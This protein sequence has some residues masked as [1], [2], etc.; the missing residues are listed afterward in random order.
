MCYALQTITK[1]LFFL[2]EFQQPDKRA[3]A[4]C[5]ISPSVSSVGRL[6]SFSP[7]FSEYGEI[8]DNQIP[9]EFHKYGC[10]Y[11]QRDLIKNPKKYDIATSHLLALNLEYI[12]RNWH[13]ESIEGTYPT[14]PPKKQ[15]RRGQ[16][17]DKPTKPL[18]PRFD[19]VALFVNALF[20]LDEIADN[21]LSTSDTSA[22]DSRK[23]KEKLKDFKAT[24]AVFCG[25]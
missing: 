20:P 16:E 8:R 24:G 13:P 12:F 23:I 18:P 6:S 22:N 9:I 7:L 17:V 4:A 1:W 2:F 21:E 10:A 14:Y 5:T 25:W 11:F 3:V 15:P 19:I